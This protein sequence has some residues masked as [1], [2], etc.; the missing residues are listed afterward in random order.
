M[1][2]KIKLN[3]LDEDIYYRKLSDETKMTIDEINNNQQIMENINTFCLKFNIDDPNKLIKKMVRNK[4]CTYNYKYIYE[5]T[6][7][8]KYEKNF[9]KFFTINL[10]NG[11]NYENYYEVVMH[12]NI[13]HPQIIYPGSRWDS[14]PPRI[15]KNEFMSKIMLNPF[16]I[17][18]KAH[19]KFMLKLFDSAIKKIGRRS[20]FKKFLDEYFKLC[21]LNDNTETDKLLSIVHEDSEIH[22]Y[23]IMPTHAEVEKYIQNRIKIE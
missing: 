17:P 21:E 7:F 22:N 12:D 10:I 23:Y 4:N 18:A 20:I 1:E 8:D 6:S 5:N 2:N 11:K 19:N 14:F 3:L 9:Y 16:C 13:V 15:C